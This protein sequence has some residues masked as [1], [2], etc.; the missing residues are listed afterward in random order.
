MNCDSE[1]RNTFSS[2]QHQVGGHKK[3]RFVVWNERRVLKPKLKEN[4]FSRE[5]EFYERIQV[6]GGNSLYGV[7]FFAKYYGIVLLR[8][9][10]ELRP[11]KI[12]TA[13]EESN[14]TA[15]PYLVLEN[16][17]F[18]ISNPCIIDIKLGTQ[19]YE[20][21][22]SLEKIRY[23]C[24]KYPF[25]KDLGFRFTGFKIFDFQS[26]EYNS[27]DKHLCRQLIPEK[28]LLY[29]IALAFFNGIIFHTKILGKLLQKIGDL[30]RWMEQQNEYN[31]YSSSLLVVYSSQEG[32]RG[33]SIE[34][35]DN[36]KK[37]KDGAMKDEQEDCDIRM[38]DFGHVQ[39]ISA[40]LVPKDPGCLHGLRTLS[41]Y[42]QRV[43]V[44]I[45]DDS[46]GMEQHAR[47]LMRHGNRTTT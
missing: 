18:R 32:C 15:V 41:V 8:L 17:T 46:S 14:A 2:F 4:L 28:D 11:M 24:A 7:K 33:D 19:T 5:I 21:Y 30:S 23:E 9:D 20:P 47:E 22:A 13:D 29:G 25:Q 35:G 40:P 6:A 31:F 43:L 45:Q 26:R 27:F 10:D 16:I 12:L 37:K 1:I 39:Y 42:L 38:I 36:D 34:G 44:L 3:S